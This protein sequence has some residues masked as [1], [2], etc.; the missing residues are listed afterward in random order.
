[1]HQFG[2]TFVIK[3]FS[4]SK[5]NVEVTYVVLNANPFHS[6]IN[7]PLQMGCKELLFA[8][9]QKKEDIAPL[10]INDPSLLRL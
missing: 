2:V 8:I 9:F 1:M 7:Q 4:L 3:Y 6:T 10:K 5:V